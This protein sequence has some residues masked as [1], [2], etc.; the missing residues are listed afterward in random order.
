MKLKNTRLRATFAPET[1]FTLQPMPNVPFRANV[2]TDFDRL[3]KELLDRQLARTGT[4]ELNA[5]VRRAANEAS[6]LAWNTLFPLLVF[7]V[8]FEEKVAEAVR[9]NRRQA[10]IY[11]ATSEIM[12]A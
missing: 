8:L 3:K 5:P 6:A 11:A 9:H 12:A 2:E 4:I 1:R 7:P 10:Q